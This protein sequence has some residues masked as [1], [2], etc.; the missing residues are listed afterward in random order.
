[1]GLGW[2]KPKAALQEASGPAV[3]GSRASSLRA[4]GLSLRLSDSL[5][6]QAR[7]V[8]LRGGTLPLQESPFLSG[9]ERGLQRQ[10]SPSVCLPAG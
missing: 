5:K 8:G 1:M 3:T 2:G 7:Q 10:G 9:S 6:L 4:L